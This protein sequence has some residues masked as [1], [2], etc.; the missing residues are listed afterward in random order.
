MIIEWLDNPETCYQYMVR[1]VEQDAEY[2]KFIAL[3]KTGYMVH[4][5]EIDCFLEYMK[6]FQ[7]RYTKYDDKDK[8][9][10][11]T[12]VRYLASLLE[13]SKD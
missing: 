1:V 12:A 5:T 6:E 7:N 9:V 8:S 4:Q 11:F 2:D 10:L 3:L 13:L